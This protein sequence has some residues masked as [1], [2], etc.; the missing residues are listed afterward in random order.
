MWWVNKKIKM[1]TQGYIFKKNI[2]MY[3]K[4]KEES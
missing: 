4:A 1:N 3:L 2:E